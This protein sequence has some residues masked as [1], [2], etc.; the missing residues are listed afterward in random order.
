MVAILLGVSLWRLSAGPVSL[1]PLAPYLEEALSAE[2]ASY[3]V[4]VDDV[5]LTWA[6]WDRTLDVRA[7][8]VQAFSADGMVLS[9]IPEMSVVL[10]MAAL[11]RGM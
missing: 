6:G 5:I 1:A 2:D 11:T 8:G 10:S 4:F 3:R 7:V 9:R